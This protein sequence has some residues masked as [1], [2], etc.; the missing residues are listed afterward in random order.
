MFHTKIS[1]LRKNKGVSQEQLAD[2][3]CTSRQAVSKWERGESYPDIEKLRDLAVYFNVSIDYL[4][5]VDLTSV[6]VNNFI[7]RMNKALENQTY[8]VPLDEIKLVVSANPNTF[9]LLATAIIYLFAILATTRNLVCADYIVE[10]GKKALL[11]Y[12]E[13]D[14][15]DVTYNDI[16]IWIIAALIAKEEY[17]EVL[18]FL[19]ENNV[20]NAEVYR[21][22]CEFELRHEEAASSIV[23]STFLS[24][25][26][27]II[28][29]QTVQ[30]GI[31]LRAG[32][33]EEALDLARWGTSFIRSIDKKE[34]L[35]LT[36]VF[37]FKFAEALTEMALGLDASAERVFL[38]E[39]Y[40]KMV[41][42]EDN[43]ESI[44]FYYSKKI[45]FLSGILDKKA[46][47]QRL[48]ESL[49]QDTPLYECGKQL[50][51]EVF[52]PVK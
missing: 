28:N 51:E 11:V 46:T 23:S 18:K 20:Q 52:L 38:K 31:L 4:L 29:G 15:I 27:Q 39:N 45:T 48:V 43:T 22:L 17:T 36:A 33:T 34:D 5:D 49:P 42:I 47:L 30:L 8:D 12:R 26:S 3:L 19:D 44:K 21:A 6:S 32:K 2:L 1:E 13:I 35:F 10:F 40:P 14:G 37:T 24:S 9:S 16:Q 41:A 7:E 25:I 50:F